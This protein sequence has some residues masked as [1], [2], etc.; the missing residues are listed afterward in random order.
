MRPGN[1]LEKLHSEFLWGTL[2]QRLVSNAD[3]VASFPRGGCLLSPLNGALIFISTLYI[4]LILEATKAAWG[5]YI[6][7]FFELLSNHESVQ[8]FNYKDI[9]FSTLYHSRFLKRFSTRIGGCI[10]MMGY[11]MLQMPV[12]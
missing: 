6:Y 7:I 12:V 2:N 11:P 3:P 10:M 8:R 5:I 9:Y 1:Q 4:L